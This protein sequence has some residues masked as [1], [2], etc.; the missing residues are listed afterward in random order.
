MMIHMESK[1]LYKMLKNLLSKED[2]KELKN[3]A[4]KYIYGALN[5]NLLMSPIYFI[6][7]KPIEKMKLMN[8]SYFSLYAYSLSHRIVSKKIGS[9]ND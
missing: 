4:Y 5:Y 9:N 2:I 8:I 3:E 1:L 7:E 6:S